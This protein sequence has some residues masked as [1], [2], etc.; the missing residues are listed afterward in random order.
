MKDE[1]ILEYAFQND[2]LIITED[3]DFGELTV[4]FKLNTKGIVLLRFLNLSS[5]EKGK[6]VLNAFMKHEKEMYNSLTVLSDKKIRIKKII[7]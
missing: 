1:Q 3:K 5:E 6:I 4:R 2:C 7:I